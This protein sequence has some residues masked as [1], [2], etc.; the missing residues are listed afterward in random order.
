MMVSDSRSS[1]KSR[2]FE[3]DSSK[4]KLSNG[5]A[6]SASGSGIGDTSSLRRSTR[7]TPSKKQMTPSP[8]STRK[9]ERLEKLT[10]VSPPNK[11]KSERQG[12]PSPL[13][14]SDRGKI[15]TSSSSSSLKNSGSGPG[16][17]AMKQKKGETEKSMKQST[18]ET[19]QVR[20]SEKHNLEIV[21]GKAKRMDGHTFKAFFKIQRTMDTASDNDEVLERP[22]KLSQVDSS[23][24][25]G[26]GSMQ[27]EDRHD[28]ADECSGRAGEELRNGCE[29]ASDG[30]IGRSSSYKKL[31]TEVPRICVEIKLSSSNRKHSSAEES[32]RPPD[33][34][35]ET[36]GDSEAVL[37]GCSA[38]NNW[39]TPELKFA[40]SVGKSP[41]SDID[42][43]SGDRGLQ[44]KR[45]RSTTDMDSSPSSGCK[46]QDVSETG[47]S[48]SKRSR[49]DDDD[50]KQDVCNTTLNK[51]FCGTSHNEVRLW[52]GTLREKKIKSCYCFFW[53]FTG[54]AREPVPG[55]REAIDIEIRLLFKRLRLEFS[56]SDLLLRTLNYSSPARSDF[57]LVQDR[58]GLEH[59]AATEN[60]DGNTQQEKL[61]QHVAY[62]CKSDSSRFLEF[63][64]PVQLSNVQLEQYCAT[65]LSNSIPLCSCSKNDPVGALRD[66][67]IS[68]RK[69][70]DHP[71]IVDPPLQS[72]ITKGLPEIKY[73]DVGIQASGKLQLL[74]IILSEIRSRKLRVLI[75]FQSIGGSG[76]DSIGD[77]L[78]D[79]LRQRFGPDSYERVDGGLIPSKKQAALNKFNDKKSGRFVFLLENRAC[80]PSIKLTSVDTVVVFDSDWN[81][82]NDIRA[83]NKIS[84]DSHFEQIKIFRLYSSCTV[85]EK[86]L[87]LAKHD[88]SLDSK[89]LNISRS[90]SDS[91]LM[92]G[93]SYQ[94]NALDEFH[95]ASNA[96]NPPEQS[97]LNDV[98]KEFLD[99]IS[100]DG[101]RSCTSNIIIRVQQNGD[102]GSYCTNLSLLGE[103]KVHLSDKEQPHVYWTKLLT[104]RSPRWKYASGQTQRQ[105]KRVQYFESPKKPEAETDEVR[106]K[107]KKMIPNFTDPPG[108]KPGLVEGEIA[109]DSEASLLKCKID[110]KESL[111]LAKQHLDFI[112]K[113]EEANHVYSRLRLLKRMFLTRTK[114]NKE[115]E[116]AEELPKEP[117]DHEQAPNYEMPTEDVPKSV[118]R[119]RKKCEKRMRRLQLQHQ[120]EVLEFHRIWE[121]KRTQLEKEH[122]VESAL[123]RSIHSHLRIDKLK[124]LDNEYTEKMEEHKRQKDI[125]LK[126]L[127]AKQLVAINEERQ[128][129]SHLLAEAK[130][131]ISEDRAHYSKSENQAKYTPA[132]DHEA[133]KDPDKVV[134]VPKHVV[135]EAAPDGRVHN[136]I[137]GSS[138]PADTP[139]NLSNGVGSCTETVL[140]SPTSKNDRLETAASKTSGP[141]FEERNRVGSLTNGC[142]TNVSLSPHNSDMQLFA[143][144]QGEEIVADEVVGVI[145][146]VEM[147]TTAI[148][149]CGYNDARTIIGFK[150]HDAAETRNAGPNNFITSNSVPL[151]EAVV[152][153]ACYHSL[154]EN[155]SLTTTEAQDECAPCRGTRSSLQGDA[156]QI[157]QSNVEAPTVEPVEQL[158]P[159]TSTSLRLGYSQPHITPA[160]GLADEPHSPSQNVETS[161]QVVVQAAGL[162]DPTV[163]QTGESPLENNQPDILSASRILIQPS[164]RLHSSSQNA[165]LPPQAVQDSAEPLNHALLQSGVNITSVQGLS[166][167][168]LHSELQGAFRTLTLPM[169]ADPLQNEMERIRKE[170]E[171]T[172]KIHEDTK[173]LLKSECEKELEA[174]IAQIRSKYEA[175]LQNIEAAFV[176]RKNELEANQNKVLMNKILADAFRSKCLDLRPSGAPGTQ[177]VMPPSFLQQ[178][179]QVQAQSALRTSGFSGSSLAGQAA[180]SHQIT[181]SPLQI[182][183]QSAALASSLACQP[184][185]THHIA[186]PPLQIVHQSAALFS[187]TPSRSPSIN[188][189]TPFSSTASR[190]HNIDPITPISS[191]PARPPS[192]NPINLSMGNLRVGAEIRA[193]APH[194]Q[195]FRRVV[196]SQQ[197]LGT[198]PVTSSSLHLPLPLPL[199][200]PPLSTPPPPTPTNHSSLNRQPQPETAGALPVN[201]SSALSALELLMDM[202]NRQ[203]TPRANI[204][205]PPPD[206]ASTFQQLDLSEFGIGSSIRVSSAPLVAETDVVCL[207]D[208]D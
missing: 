184:A 141:M 61:S 201:N 148:E 103:L 102:G 165:D 114:K 41:E 79:F 94:F 126:D 23:S 207:S 73:L 111:A 76:R 69:C 19:R 77:I 45:K 134:P 183:H 162:L 127:E 42:Q 1:R 82:S 197:A 173:V 189:M 129:A 199:P 205:P 155:L 119:V 144:I 11:M 14:R 34:D 43:G 132:S 198:P 120:E 40:A 190:P 39:Q 88:L 131:S 67:L 149:S 186:A 9:S 38:E 32:C 185:S 74:D 13:R 35:E 6:S 57:L 22:D 117:L 168:P 95:S 159:S 188:P 4:K 96:S 54:I 163:S 130:S 150:P 16:S 50:Q 116:D 104:G 60:C 97:L 195:P 153:P 107:H 121:E 53:G 171:Q 27:V 2:D 109:G 105:R 108:Q 158:Q 26:N 91:L 128:K 36:L 101:K 157:H 194:L 174:M 68:T 142:D 192:I 169:Y 5:K 72:L 138:S 63:W 90:T 177:Q 172:I 78:D 133:F 123:V 66:I 154:P 31:D 170:T 49:G 44:H 146:S 25:A 59:C 55:A 99:L 115:S 175:Q 145:T 80:L 18:V 166:N 75:L 98:V 87:I 202:D 152:S 92:W 118:K 180:T 30:A 112:C 113:E 48:C 206:V 110:R 137:M 178:L 100:Q 10:P 156:G 83:L 20:R 70:C 56:A 37:V 106:K 86:V 136:M 208:D 85:E 181:A 62:D 3:R 200:R 58:V 21:G 176:L 28:E 139:V 24:G 182:V 140:V 33:G 89:L 46:G 17:S 125:S 65:L 203:N 191:T 151:V 12:V 71:Y 160:S 187:S 179:Q 8:C 81:P 29:R 193:P 93:A 47:V 7:E 51:E 122:R 147:E 204:L 143:G 161:S 164:N 124:V 167:V 196:P 52:D 135:E 64:V 15:Q 84:I